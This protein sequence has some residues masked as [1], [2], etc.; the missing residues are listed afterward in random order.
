MIDSY[1]SIHSL[2]LS[3]QVVFSINWKPAAVFASN[4]V[5]VLYFNVQYAVPVTQQVTMDVLLVP[6]S[7]GLVDNILYRRL[8][9]LPPGIHRMCTVYKTLLLWPTTKHLNLLRVTH[10]TLE[11]CEHVHTVCTGYVFHK[12]T[13]WCNS[14]NLSELCSVWA[15]KGLLS[16]SKW[17][18]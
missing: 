6:P 8:A 7:P 12:M 17:W 10:W 16:G 2:T 11:H 3:L 15:L 5:S 14:F 1:I 13:N 4:V 18:M 9:S